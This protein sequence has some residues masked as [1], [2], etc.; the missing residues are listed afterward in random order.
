MRLVLRL[1]YSCIYAGSSQLCIS[2]LTIKRSRSCENGSAE[3]T[4]SSPRPLSHLMPCYA[5]VSKWWSSFLHVSEPQ[6]ESLTLCFYDSSILGSSIS[7][8]ASSSSPERACPIASVTLSG[9]TA[10]RA[11][12]CRG[13]PNSISQR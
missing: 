1:P 8:L 9:A 10:T 12:S 3:V 2:A 11:A 5:A 7:L 4:M 6:P 13:K